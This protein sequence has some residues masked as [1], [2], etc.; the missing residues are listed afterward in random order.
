MTAPDPADLA[1]C[2]GIALRERE[3]EVEDQEWRAL[4]R[5][6]EGAIRA[7][8]ARVAELKEASCDY[9]GHKFYALETDE[10]DA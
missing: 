10:K 9:C 2:H 7:L 8:E 4:S 3:D 1:I 5:E 6:Y